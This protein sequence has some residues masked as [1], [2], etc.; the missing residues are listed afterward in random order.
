MEKYDKIMNMSFSPD[1]KKLLFGRIRDDRQAMIHVYNLET[2]DLSAY[3]PPQGEGWYYARYSFDGRQIVF[4]ITPQ[5]RESGKLKQDLANSQIATMAPNGKN[6]RKITKSSGWKIY[7]SFSH[8]NKKVIF[9]KAGKLCQHMPG[10]F[11]D[12]PAIDYD[13]YEVVLGKDL[14]YRLTRFKFDDMSSPFYFPDDETI[15]FSAYG[16]PNMYPG[17]AE[18][19]KEAIW[20][21]QEKLHAR[22]IQG[23]GTINTSHWR[24]TLWDN[25]Y[26]V[27]KGQIEL[28]ECFIKSEDHLTN[29]Q[30]TVSGLIYFE[31]DSQIIY[32]YSPGGHHRRLNKP[33]FI[34][35]YAISPDGLLLA[36]ALG[37]PEL[38]W[39]KHRIVIYN[40]NDGTIKR[41]IS[42]PDAPAPFI[43]GE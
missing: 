41:E 35:A 22:S 7:P 17:I 11:H 27:K 13:V 18:D 43:N 30:L 9:A 31:H 36:L 15:I 8:D 23:Y 1:S 42:L 20:K 37:T 32:Q 40:A 24:G 38:E 28:P 39:E 3:K 2:G 33:L 14:E 12:I 34:K 6:V 5:N 19:D 25:I 29:P 16:A 4:S 21:E 26:V 10:T